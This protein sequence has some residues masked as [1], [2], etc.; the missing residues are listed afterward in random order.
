MFREISV[1][2]TILLWINSLCFQ[3]RVFVQKIG[4]SEAT[5]LFLVLGE[6]GGSR[7]DSSGLTKPGDSVLDSID[8]CNERKTPQAL[9]GIFDSKTVIVKKNT[10]RLQ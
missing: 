9:T 7:L 1:Y 5:I 3:F 10:V 6:Q 4:A 2:S 8:T